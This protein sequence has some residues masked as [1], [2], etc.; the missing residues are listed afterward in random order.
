MELKKF[1]CNFIVLTSFERRI[2][3]MIAA[4][5]NY[6]TTGWH[7]CTIATDVVTSVVNN[8]TTTTWS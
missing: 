6:L 8:W 3:S 2:V 4:T 7:N 5:I 1:H